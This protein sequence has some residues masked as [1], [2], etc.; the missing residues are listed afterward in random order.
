LTN[1]VPTDPVATM[2]DGNMLQIIVFA[3]LFGV[4]VTMSGAR[5]RHVLS[6]FTDL[7]AVIMH[8]VE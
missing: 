4:A 6:L 8:M 3:L 2:A 7:D 5:G 1:L